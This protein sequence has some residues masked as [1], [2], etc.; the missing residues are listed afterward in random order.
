MVDNLT[1]LTESDFDSQKHLNNP[2]EPHHPVPHRG[3]ASRIISIL[4]NRTNLSR[5]GGIM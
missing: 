4:R 1:F 3:I 2:L 5:S